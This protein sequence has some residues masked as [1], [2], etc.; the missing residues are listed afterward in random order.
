MS[1]DI[2]AIRHRP[3]LLIG[4]SAIYMRDHRPKV[5]PEEEVIQAA[6]WLDVLDNAEAWERLRAALD[7]L[8]KMRHGTKR[9]TR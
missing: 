3:D 5:G 1:H 6:A 7:A 2:D 4:Q 8:H 9:R